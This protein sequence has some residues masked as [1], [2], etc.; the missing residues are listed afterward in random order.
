MPTPH[1]FEPSSKTLY[2]PIDGTKQ[3]RSLQTD[4]DVCVAL[5]TTPASPWI[6]V[7]SSRRVDTRLWRHEDLGC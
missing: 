2:S 6:A 7:S 3:L 1:I 5:R 4:P